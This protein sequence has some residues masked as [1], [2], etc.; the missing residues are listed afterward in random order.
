M[1]R[2][3]MWFR[4]DLRLSDNPALAAAVHHAGPGGEVVAAFC[5]DERLR[6]PAG[7]P[8]LAFLAG[9]LRSLA[10]SIDGHLVIR[11]GP[12]DR[13]IPRLAGEAGAD[14]VFVA[15]DF[16]PYGRRRDQQVERALAA[17]GSA[18]VRV[19]SP[20]AV[21]PGAIVTTT[22]R[23]YQVFTPYA[24][25][26]RTH[27]W[28][29]RSPAPRGVRWWSDLDSVSIPAAP[30]VGA[31]L[32]EPGEAAGTRCA[33]RFHDRHLASYA[34][35]RDRP[36]LDATSRVSVYLK[37]G[38]L[39]PRQL[40]AELGR[41]RSHDAFRSEL[42]WRE[43]YADVLWHRP[44]TVRRVVDPTMAA[45]EV[46]QGPAADAAFHAWAD[47]RTGFPIVDAGMRQLRH[48][49]WMHNRVRMIVASF[50]VK[51]L[52]LDWTRGARHFM[53]HLVDGDIASN[54]HGW[55]WA[56]GTGTDAAPY[57]RVFNPVTQGERFDPDGTYVRRWVPELRGVPGRGIHAPWRLPGGPPPG[58]PAPIVDHA[59][60]RAE[61]LR[62]YDRARR[63]AG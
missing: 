49:A 28:P 46:D 57:F 40:L 41:S 53:T 31:R 7:P 10:A 4:R 25:A 60:A 6:R 51:D 32:P 22:G 61:A 3:V 58:Y 30:A 55:Q 8:R 23:P 50:L 45:M 13:A 21:P 29:R 17:R 37:W 15:E 34:E 12:P 52:H 20:Y 59:E 35:A 33:R 47:G 38:C 27:G 2:V 16:G 26:W 1:P 43:F 54:Q 11:A 56:A 24:R 36:D 42:C 14:R 18:L 9:C 44:D 63:R 19:G 62:R 48:E 39:H 5:L